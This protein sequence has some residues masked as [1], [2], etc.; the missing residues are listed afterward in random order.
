MVVY[1]EGF[2]TRDNAFIPFENIA[3]SNT[4]RTFVDQLLGLYDVHVSC[5][6]SGQEIRFR[7]LARGAQLSGAID[8]LIAAAQPRL[9]REA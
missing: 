7:R 1:E 4:R 2:L 9:G 6:G 8:Q 3:D 5:Q